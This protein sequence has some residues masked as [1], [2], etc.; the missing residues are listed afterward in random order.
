MQSDD[1]SKSFDRFRISPL[2]KVTL[3][4][5]YVALLLPLPF[6]AQVTTAPVS[7]GLLVALALLG[8]LFLGAGLSERV[9]TSDQGIAMVSPLPWRGWSLTWSEITALKPRSTGQNGTVY[10]LMT[11]A[12]DRAYLL[13]MRVVGFA[14]LVRT[15]EAKTGLDTQDV[16]PLAQPWMYLFLLIMTVFLLLMDAWTVWTATHGGIA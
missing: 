2:I 4:S 3:L 12:A 1:F 6:L 15:V 7:P 5:F 8:A 11:A 10:Y 16:T 13:P 9:E 14:R